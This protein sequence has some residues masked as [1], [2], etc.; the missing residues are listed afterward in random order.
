VAIDA[1]VVAGTVLV[2][3]ILVPTFAISARIALRPIVE[4]FVR[5]NQAFGSAQ[6]ALNSGRMAHLENQVAVLTEQVRRLEEA[7]EF[8]RQLKAGAPKELP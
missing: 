1:D 2:L 5:L 4:S 7:E 6:S 8:D 3:V